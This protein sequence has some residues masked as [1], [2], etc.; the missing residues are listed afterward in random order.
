MGDLNFIESFK[1]ALDRLDIVQDEIDSRSLEK[2]ELRAKIRK[3][4]DMHKLADFESYNS[5]KS[6]LWRISISDRKRQNVDKKLLAETVTDEQYDEIVTTSEYETFTV[7]K[8]KHSKNTKN[9]GV[10]PAAPKGV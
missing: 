8:V 3:W 4:M 2:D 5:D 7:K 10:A 1:T 9:G 6:R